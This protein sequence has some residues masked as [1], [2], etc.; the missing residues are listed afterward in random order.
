MDKRQLFKHYVSEKRLS[1]DLKY[2]VLWSSS[3]AGHGKVVQ[4]EKVLFA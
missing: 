1:N 4:L 2:S 3:A